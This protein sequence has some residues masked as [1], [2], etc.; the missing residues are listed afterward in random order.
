MLTE[1]A[2]ESRGQDICLAF[3]AA[4]PKE[5]GSPHCY[6]QERGM[7]VAR[8]LE[9]GRERACPVVRRRDSSHHSSRQSPTTSGKCGSW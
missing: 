4:S 7:V 1:E 8:G 9:G 6:A 5:N 3:P 2:K